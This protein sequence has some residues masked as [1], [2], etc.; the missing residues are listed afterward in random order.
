MLEEIGLEVSD[1]NEIFLLNLTFLTLDFAWSETYECF[2]LSQTL[3]M[4]IICDHYE[5]YSKLTGD[6]LLKV[7]HEITESVHSRY[8]LFKERHGYACNMKGTPT[9][10]V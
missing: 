1:N 9:T 5:D 10:T 8:R 7:S 4:H 3:K 2:Y 6:S